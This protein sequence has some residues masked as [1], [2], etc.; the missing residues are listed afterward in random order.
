MGLVLLRLD[1][2]MPR[3]GGEHWVVVADF[4]FSFKDTL[5]RDVL[6]SRKKNQVVD[7]TP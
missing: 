7:T 1:D 4:F 3:G 5:W 6:A 2:L